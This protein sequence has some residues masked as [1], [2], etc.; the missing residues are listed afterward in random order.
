MDLWGADADL[1]CVTTNGWVN[2]AS[3]KV[4]MGR[5]CAKEI[6]D[7]LPGVDSRLGSLIR[8]HG[9]RPMRFAKVNGADVVSL[10]VK[11][12][13]RQDADLALIESSIRSLVLLTNK[14]CYTNVLI[15]RPGCGNGRLKWADVR[16]VIE[17]LLDDRFTVVSK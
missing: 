17:P 8:K 11:H 2:P 7:A 9:N 14:F 1:R 4:V 3:G 15:P 12:H 5:G 10:P 6:R 13:W 16:K